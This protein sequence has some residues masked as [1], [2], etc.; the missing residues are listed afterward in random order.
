MLT[1]W[2]G[3]VVKL[4]LKVFTGTGDLSAL[5]NTRAEPQP[6]QTVRWLETIDFSSVSRYGPVTIGYSLACQELMPPAMLVTLANPDFR[7]RSR[8]TALRLPE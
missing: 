5:A 3:K 7:S 2:F 4:S 1:A 8:P 6:S